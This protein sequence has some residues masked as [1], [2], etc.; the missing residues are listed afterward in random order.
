MLNK[1]YELIENV[2][3]GEK[4]LSDC[5]YG[6]PETFNEHLLIECLKWYEYKVKNC[7]NPNYYEQLARCIIRYFIN[8]YLNKRSCFYVHNYI[9]RGEKGYPTAIYVWRV[10]RC[11]L[12]R[13]P[14]HATVKKTIYFSYPFNNL[15]YKN[16]RGSLINRGNAFIF[17]NEDCQT[18]L[19]LTKKIENKIINKKFNDKKSEDYSDYTDYY[20]KEDITRV[21]EQ[22]QKQVIK[23]EEMLDKKEKEIKE[24]N[25][26]MKKMNEIN[27]R[28]KILDDKRSEIK[29]RINKILQ[30]INN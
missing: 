22:W 7:G 17:I 9:F 2:F 19:Y 15:T 10:Y 21:N 13:I 18:S 29:N 23:L 3:N 30:L 20:T 5:I 14:K 4:S 24:L 12:K 25:E 8:S 28:N 6:K 11:I 16:R 1:C 26:K 27:E